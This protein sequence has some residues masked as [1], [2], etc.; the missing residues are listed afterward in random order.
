MC[1]VKPNYERHL[2]TQLHSGKGTGS[3]LWSTTPL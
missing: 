2:S 3:F 1:F